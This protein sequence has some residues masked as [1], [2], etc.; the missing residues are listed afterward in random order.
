MVGFFFLCAL[1]QIKAT[2]GTTLTFALISEMFGLEMSWHV[3]LDTSPIYNMTSSIIFTVSSWTLQS[4][5]TFAG[6]FMTSELLHS[7]H[8]F[9]GHQE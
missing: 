4:C 7:C 8:S 2:E 9:P 5:A 3:I 1:L 6:D